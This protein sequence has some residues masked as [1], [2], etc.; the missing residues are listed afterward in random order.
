MKTN[1]TVKQE[2]NHPN[3]GHFAKFVLEEER[4]SAMFEMVEN[5]ELEEEEEEEEEGEE[6]RKRRRKEIEEDYEERKKDGYVAEME[7][8]VEEK[9]LQR[10]HRTRNFL[11][12]SSVSLKRSSQLVRSDALSPTS[13]TRHLV[14]EG[15]EIKQQG[16]E[17]VGEVEIEKRGRNN[18]VGIRETPGNSREP[19][20]CQTTSRGEVVPRDGGGGGVRR[21]SHHSQ[22]L[23]ASSSA[24]TPLDT[25][26][27]RMMTKQERLACFQFNL[28]RQLIQLV[29]TRESITLFPFLSFLG[30]ILFDLDVDLPTGESRVKPV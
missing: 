1:R 21:K 27:V 9:M 2:W 24:P 7:E 11:E 17:E 14:M 30:G 4:V 5:Q 18:G 28:D 20:D 12:T 19:R 25:L 26:P 23:D 29:I 3:K 10:G 16:V 8:A 6:E 15:E 22:S 13:I